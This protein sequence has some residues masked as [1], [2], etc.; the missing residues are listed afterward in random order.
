M[1]LC[2]R[3][4]YNQR[5]QTSSNNPQE[6]YSNTIAESSMHTIKNSLIQN[7]NT[8]QAWAR[9]IHSRQAVMAKS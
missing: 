6:R 3:G 1:L 8:K 2:Q 4:K 5:S 9:L 7:Q